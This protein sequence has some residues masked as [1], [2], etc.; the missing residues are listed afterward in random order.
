MSMKK[1]YTAYTLLEVL[2]VLGIIMV[3]GGVT[4]SS[5]F[6]LHDTV[7]M[8]EYM[9]TLERDIRGIQRASMLLERNPV[10]NWLYGLGIDLTQIDDDGYYTVFKWCSPFVDY[11]DITTRSKVPAYNPEEDIE[12]ANFPHTS[13][14]TGILCGSGIDPGDKTQLRLIPEYRRTVTT[15]RSNV[16]YK[17]NAR[18]VVFESVSGRAFFYDDEGKLLNYKITD[19]VLVLKDK[20]EIEHFE[21][22]ITPVSRGSSRT[23]KINHLSGRIDNQF[24][25]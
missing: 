19:G 2:V 9:M 10:E 7:K 5:F 6:G 20:E 16:I 17:S 8:N 25:K 13:V 18:Y 4:L 14:P 3:V 24:R 15:P 12:S 21:I 22:E 23:L 1:K 11:G